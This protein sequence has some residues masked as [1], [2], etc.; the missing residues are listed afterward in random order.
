MVLMPARGSYRQDIDLSKG[1]HRTN[2]I[3]RIP[4]RRNTR[5]RPANERDSQTVVDS[6]IADTL[7]AGISMRLRCIG[8]VSRARTYP[9]PFLPDIG[10]PRICILQSRVNFSLRNKTLIIVSAGLSKLA[11]VYTVSRTA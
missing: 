7:G 6:A 5:S 1:Y 4:T 8:T 2:V 10:D 3:R 11:E 9:P